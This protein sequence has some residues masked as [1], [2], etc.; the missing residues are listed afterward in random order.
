MLM[1]ST[2]KVEKIVMNDSPEWRKISADLARLDYLRSA[3]GNGEHN[4]SLS[5][6]KFV[7]GIEDQFEEHPN[8]GYQE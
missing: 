1:N 8:A 2:F 4:V 5:C 6:I 3:S 7:L